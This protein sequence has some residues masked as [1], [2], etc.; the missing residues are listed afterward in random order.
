M[1]GNVKDCIHCNLCKKNCD[2]LK[3]Y[4]MDLE[5]FSKRED[6]AY[7]CFL[8]GKCNQVCPKDI[9]GKEIALNMREKNVKENNHQ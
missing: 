9:D 1:K 2:F 8:C 5:G 7:H 4:D 3:K 6:L